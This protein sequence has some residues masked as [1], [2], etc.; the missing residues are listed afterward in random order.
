MSD[1]PTLRAICQQELRA[2]DGD[3]YLAHLFAHETV[4]DHWLLLS[5]MYC[6]LRRVERETT[7]PMVQ[8]IRLQWWADQISDTGEFKTGSGPIV[9]F[10]SAAGL[11]G[12]PI[13]D[14]VARLMARCEG[15]DQVSVGFVGAQFF[16]MLAAVTSSKAAPDILS[17][18]GAFWETWREYGQ[19]QRASSP[20]QRATALA[21]KRD[22]NALPRKTRRAFVPI[23]LVFGMCC[24]HLQQAPVRGS[25][26]GYLIYLV[27]RSITLKL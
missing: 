14:L 20:E 3:L 27:S 22:L 15:D 7:E 11:D 5:L 8:L 24:R 9:D 16:M 2:L 26:L 6:H 10:A 17:E 4:R 25:T 19:S 1:V 23:I 12:R 18:A 13:A 21:I